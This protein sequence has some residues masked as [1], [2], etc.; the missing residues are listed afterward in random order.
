MRVKRRYMVALVILLLIA[1]GYTYQAA[2]V[3]KDMKEMLPPGQMIDINGHRMHIYANG[4]KEGE[5]TM[6]LTSGSGTTSPFADFY[7]LYSRLNVNRHVVLYERPGYGWSEPTE[8]NRDI[9]VITAELHELLKESGEQGPYVL[10]AHSMGSLE[11]IRFAQLY[12]NEVLAL[13]M[14]DGI[15]P[16]YARDFRM[17]PLMKV[18][19]EAMRAAKNS[20]LLRGLS[21]FGVT[22]EL[23]IDIAELPQ[24]LSDTKVVMSLKNINNDNM[25]VE[26]N[27]M[28]ENGQK[29]LAGDSLGDL[30][31]LQFY[32][33]NNG[34]KN[35][36]E[37]Q[38]Q[39]KGLSTDVK[40]VV[41]PDAKHYIHH[42]K[43]KE[44]VE[45]LD[46]FLAQLH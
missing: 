38:D 36:E 37:T 21:E 11:M 25:K 1:S 9:D 20:G 40:Q 14:I 33:T 28:S 34:Y 17:T 15:S 23:F 45:E 35:W 22:D 44:I 3:R 8:D 12:P 42:Q 6:V 46:E 10:M 41:F 43:S 16:Q 2:G 27:A 5:Y 24:E 29:V 30:P 18:G 19:W 39:L 26:M 31:M 7:P 4:K 13:V 32:A